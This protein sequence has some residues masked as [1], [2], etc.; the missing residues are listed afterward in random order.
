MVITKREDVT[1][2]GF[3]KILWRNLRLQGSLLLEL[4]QF[5]EG[6]GGKV[7]GVGWGGC[8]IEF[9]CDRER[10]RVGWALIRG[11]NPRQNYLRKF[12]PSCP[13]SYATKLFPKQRLCG[14]KTPSPDSM[15][16][17]TN[18]Q[19]KHANKKHFTEAVLSTTFHARASSHR[20]ARP[21]IRFLQHPL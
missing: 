7:G 12:S 14:K 1:K 17:P 13:L 2:Q 4:I 3:C 6:G 19:Q 15:L 11:C 8:F 18:V 20:K 9:E 10:G 16:L 5:W 21:H